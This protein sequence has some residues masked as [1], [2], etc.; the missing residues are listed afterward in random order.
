MKSTPPVH[1][2]HFD[3]KEL[4]ARFEMAPWVEIG[5]KPCECPKQ[6]EVEVPEA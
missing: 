3:V 1:F 5:P 6:P 4:E 2:D